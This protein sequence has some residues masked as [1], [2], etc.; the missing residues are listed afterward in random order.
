MGHT[1]KS[2]DPRLRQVTSWPLQTLWDTEGQDLSATR[3]RS[4]GSEAIKSLLRRGVRRFAVV[5]FDPQLRWLDG[6]HGLEFWK[7]EARDHLYEE[8]RPYM[9]DYP[10]EYFYQASEWITDSGETIIL[11]EIHH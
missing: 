5:G 2:M 1:K 10:G 3:G 9:E 11:F 7:D 6:A 4:L 8:S